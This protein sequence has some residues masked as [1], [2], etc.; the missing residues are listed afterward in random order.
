[1]ARAFPPNTTPSHPYRKTELKASLTRLSMATA[2]HRHQL[3]LTG[4]IHP[5]RKPL[6]TPEDTQIARILFKTLIDY[7]PERSSRGRYKPAV[8]IEETFGRIQCKDAFL[9]YF[10]TYIYTN[11]TSEEERRTG[12]DFC[13]VFTYFR[14]FSSWSSKDKDTAMDT[15]DNFAEYLIDNFFMPRE[16][17]SAYELDLSWEGLTL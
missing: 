11:V 10:F 12:S 9:E 14:D 6:L 8:L 15:I 16:L 1:M 2:H 17:M 13:Q 7:A 3:S 4:F 5:P